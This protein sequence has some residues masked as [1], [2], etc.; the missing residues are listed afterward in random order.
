MLL[1]PQVP[2]PIDSEN[3]SALSKLPPVA[4]QCDLVDD[5]AADRQRESQLERAVGRSRMQADRVPGALVAQ[6]PL[7]E[8]RSGGEV[9]RTIERQHRRQLLAGERVFGPD[10]IL[11]DDQELRRAKRRAV[12]HGAR[13]DRTGRLRDERRRELAAGEHRRL[14]LSRLPGIEQHAA[15]ARES[16]ASSAS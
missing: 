13:G 11:A 14:Q 1:P 12:Q 3:G 16:H 10:A 6:Q 2:Q 9:V 7:R 15:F 8:C 5:H 4:K